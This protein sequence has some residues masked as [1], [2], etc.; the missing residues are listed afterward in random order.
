MSSQKHTLLKPNSPSKGGL[1]QEFFQ[2]SGQESFHDSKK[3]LENAAQRSPDEYNQYNDTSFQRLKHQQSFEKY[4]FHPKQSGES[5]PN[6]SFKKQREAGQ[7]ENNLV[8]EG[9]TKSSRV[10]LMRDLVSQ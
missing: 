5:S 3:T 2:K 4:Y 1:Y 9:G 8:I 10:F 6:R 7:K